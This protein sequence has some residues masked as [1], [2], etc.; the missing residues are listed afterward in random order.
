[1]TARTTAALAGIALPTGI[2]ITGVAA[3]R[4]DPL[5]AL[6]GLTLVVIGLAAA[7]T[8]TVCAAV[9]NT[10]L[11]RRQL[12]E[13]KQRADSLYM[14]SIAARAIVD[15]DAERLCR[16]AAA[17]EA[18]IA[19]RLAAER[20]ALQAEFEASRTAVKQ[21]GYF[22]GLAHGQRTI[23]D[24]AA[25]PHTGRMATVIPL[26]TPPAGSESTVGSGHSS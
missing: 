22:I 19:Q 9:T 2:A 14:R 24:A 5:T 21:E 23:A 25:G 8:H 10:E 3:I 12:H 7:V 4:H 26:P 18:R 1:M 13:A 6:I 16:E 11:E 17:L 20:E 15:A